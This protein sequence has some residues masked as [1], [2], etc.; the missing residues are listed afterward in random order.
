MLSVLVL[1]AAICMPIIG[2]VAILGF[3]LLLR[4][5]RLR[6][7]SML[8]AR[9]E[10]AESIVRM[11]AARPS[12][13]VLFVGIVVAMVGLALSVALYPVGF[14]VGSPYPYGLGPWM[15]P[16]VSTTLIGIA[17]VIWHLLAIKS[18]TNH[19]QG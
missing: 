9:G 18:R 14:L 8:L 4:Y 16:G 12:R 19:R 5:M 6:E 15:V 1:L 13:V 10:A 17:L 2:L 7:T 11:R 3:V